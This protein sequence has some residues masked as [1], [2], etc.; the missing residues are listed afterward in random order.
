M[1]HFD[2]MNNLGFK[3]KQLREEQ[4]ISQEDLA[5]ELNIS[6]SKLS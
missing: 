1:T 2:N 6:Q 4:N 5:D 3:L